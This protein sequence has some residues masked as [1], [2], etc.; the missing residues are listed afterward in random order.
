MSSTK[1]ARPFDERFW[2][3]VNKQGANGCWEWTGSLDSSGYGAIKDTAPSKKN[4]RP[5]RYIMESLG[6]NITGLSVLHKCDN[7]KCL[8][9]DHLFVGTQTDNIRDM[10]A[11][12]RAKTTNG[13]RWW[14]DGK[15]AMMSMESP[16]PIWRL[17]RV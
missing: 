14:T 17:G 16:G 5:H 13:Y 11:K 7:P 1:T 9:P 12:G 4:I 10:V 3:K 15:Q 6:H 2:P 8:N